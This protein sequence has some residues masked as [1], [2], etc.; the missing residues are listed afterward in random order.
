MISYKTETRAA[1]ENDVM[2]LSLSFNL[3]D[4]LSPQTLQAA[5]V[6]VLVDELDEFESAVDDVAVV[7]EDDVG[8]NGGLSK[9]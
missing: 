4:A 2:H 9:N 5:K 8:E 1:N 6:F 3:P 7:F